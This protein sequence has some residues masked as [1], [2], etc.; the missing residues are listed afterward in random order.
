MRIVLHTVANL[1]FG[2]VLT[3]NTGIGEEETLVGCETVLVLQWLLSCR[4]LEG[5][6][7]YHQTAVVGKVLTQSE[8]AVGIQIRQYLDVAEEI[9]IHIRTLVETLGISWRPPILQVTAGI[10]L[11]TLVVETVGHLMTDYH[12]DGTIVEC[13]VGLGIEERILKNSG[14]EADFVGGWVV[15]CVHG[16]R[17]HEP[18]FLIHWLTCLLG[19]HLVGTELTAHQ[20]VLVETLGWVDG[21]L[22]VVSPLLWITNLHV[23]LAELVVGCSLGF[24]A[25]PFLSV[26][27]LTETDLQVLHQRLHHLLG[28]FREEF[29]AVDSSECLAHL[30]LYLRCGTLPQWVIFLTAA[31]GLSEEIE[32]CHADI[33]A[34]V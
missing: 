28:R 8:A 13:L 31:H 1:L 3:P 27:A 26:D 25:H 22:A 9:S 32:V 15:V 5:I 7:G 34:Q 20:Y 6:E 10:I 12:A 14:W 17:S 30:I 16:L 33:V 29:L 19:Y 2:D 18:L 24:S 21:Q 11:A 4:I 23:E